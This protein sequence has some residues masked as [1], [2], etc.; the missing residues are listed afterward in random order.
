MPR[1]GMWAS[2]P[3]GAVSSQMPQECP[4]PTPTGRVGK[5]PVSSL[6]PRGGRLLNH[7]LVFARQV[8]NGACD[9]HLSNMYWSFVWLL[10]ICATCPF[11]YQVNLFFRIL[12]IAFINVCSCLDLSDAAGGGKVGC[13]WSKVDRPNF[14]FSQMERGWPVTF[15]D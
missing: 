4:T 7:P 11:F 9:L 6:S 10:P 13:L 5:A 2:V 12:K 8:E 15:T 3:R 1:S 14:Y